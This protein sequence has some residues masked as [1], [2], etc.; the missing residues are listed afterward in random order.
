MKFLKYMLLIRRVEYRI[1]EIPIMGIP[2][3][4][5]LQDTA[6]LHTFA[7]WEGVFLFLLLFAFGDMVN[8]L[9]D[10]DLDSVSKPHLS[11]AIKELGEGFVRAQLIAY[12]LLALALSVH[13]AWQLNRW[14]FPLLILLGIPLGAAYSVP[15]VRTKGR[16]LLHALTLWAVIFVG[17]M[18]LAAQLVS[19]TVT[20]SLTLLILAYA[21]QQTGIV[22]IN[23]A[24]DYLEDQAMNVRT[25]IVALGLK[26]G[27]ALAHLLVFAGAGSLFAAFLWIFR[28][29]S[30][31][32]WAKHAPWL[33][34]LTGMIVLQRTSKTY[35]HIQRLDMATAAKVVKEA[36]K[37]VPLWITATA[38]TAQIVSLCLYL[39]RR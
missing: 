21:T 7:F 8:C 4:L 13:L 19:P 10:K 33:I 37:E 31:T 24:E 2:I 14:S 23:S 5:L 16:G 36:A 20:L 34:L 30:V 18:F 15:P 17:P 6:P 25:T 1:A 29:Q 3:S 12:A 27:V 38:W 35:R 11:D 32:G 39:T 28:E 26:R 22:L 9:Y